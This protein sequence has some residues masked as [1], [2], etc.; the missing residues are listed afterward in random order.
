MTATPQSN[1]RNAIVYTTAV[2]P[3]D[4]TPH[5]L[6]WRLHP[7]FQQQA[8][9]GVLDDVGWVDDVL[10]NEVT[11]HILDGHLRVALALEQGA[12]TVPV[13]YVHLTPEEELQVLA[14]LDPIAALAE[15]DT[16]QRQLLLDG[17]TSDDETVQTLIDGLLAPAAEVDDAALKDQVQK[18]PP[19]PK[20]EIRFVIGP[21]R[22][23]VDLKVYTDWVNDLYA[24][25]H[26]D[27]AAVLADISRRLGLEDVA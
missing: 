18:P 16:A 26:G 15:V 17:L 5:P 3:G 10:V 7:A 9:A 20:L 12:A 19:K 14:L 13:S 23:T 24:Q 1:W 8:L 2:P 27:G 22:F 6:N 25:Y 11:G 4:L 21:Y